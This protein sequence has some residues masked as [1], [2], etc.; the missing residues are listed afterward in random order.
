M[1]VISR[2]QAWRNP[3]FMEGGPRAPRVGH[4][5]PNPD[6]D[7]SVDVHPSADRMFSELRL[8]VP[9][10][11]WRNI[12]YLRITYEWTNETSTVYCGWVDSVECISDSDSAAVT[13]VKWHVDEWGTWIGTAVLGYGHRLRRPYTNE[14]TTPIQS[15]ERKFWTKGTT[16]DLIPKYNLDGQRTWWVLL[17]AGVTVNQEKIVQYFT[18]PIAKDNHTYIIQPGAGQ[19][20]SSCPQYQYVIAGAW[21]EMLGLDPAAV[22]GVWILPCP[23]MAASEL[24]TNG[25]VIWTT[26][27]VWQYKKVADGSAFISQNYPASYAALFAESST[28]M[29]SKTATQLKPLKVTGFSGEILGE[30]PI[31]MSVSNYKYR[32]V[33]SATECYIE[34]RLDDWYSKAI[35]TAF[36]VPALPLDLTQNAWSSY[37]Y[38]GQRE[39]DITSRKNETYKRG[40]EDTV[41]GAAQGALIGGFGGLGAGAG[42][43]AGAISGVTKF[44]SEYLYFNEAAQSASDKL[45]ASQTAGI[46]ISG[47]AF[48]AM[49]HGHDIALSEFSMDSYSNTRATNERSQIGVKVDEYISDNSSVKSSTGFYQ[50]VNLEVGGSI[51]NSAKRYIAN[52]FAQGVILI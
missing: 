44:Y 20:G 51:P 47:G 12:C 48:D 17:A 7:L 19:S 4:S 30:V 6:I 40:I 38:S 49:E 8:P 37:Q 15:Y 46:L 3:G 21:D 27:S 9:F 33:A 13:A 39:Y 45:A 14:A 43:A 16:I 28:V 25:N 31:G 36:T 42:A 2:I 32:T 34:I 11:E 35:G 5:L 26:S 24:Q 23:P 52:R 10:D 41:S 50:I 1:A 22:Y 29:T 18:W